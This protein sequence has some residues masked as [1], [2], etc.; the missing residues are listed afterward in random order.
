MVQKSKPRIA[1]YI[2]LNESW[3][4]GINYYR[5]LFL[6]L[7]YVENK[8]YEYFIFMPLSGKKYQ[9]ENFSDANVIYNDNF[10][11]KFA[12][13]LEMYILKYEIDLLSHMSIISNK[14]NC[15]VINWIPDFQHKYL[16]NYF[17]KQDIA[18]RDEK[19][20]QY[21]KYADKVLLSSYDA[22]KDFHKFFSRYKNKSAVL[23]FVA[24]INFD[25]LKQSIA[26]EDINKS[27]NKKFFFLPNQFWQHKNHLTVFKAILELKKKNIEIKLLCSG[28]MDDYRNKEHADMLKKFLYNNN[29]DNNIKLLG[30][31][32]SKKLYKLM[33]ESVC[34]INP[35]LFE[36]WST[37]VEECKTLC[38][39][40]I[41][42]DL[43]VHQ[44][45]N[46]NGYYFPQTDY[47]ALADILEEKWLSTKRKNIN[48]ADLEINLRQKLIIMGTTFENILNEIFIK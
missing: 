3:M 20:E 41:L 5:N 37:T 32:S 48:I 45:Q 19:F 34:V 4:G 21:A 43:N 47:L 17:S 25:E 7:K 9:L 27:K 15:K 28:H 46:P 13:T 22:E 33:W 29:L 39:D 23:R 30:S 2:N 6:S 16:P 42:S 12:D 1:F 36:G 40:M 11:I 31:I 35:S 38:K 8:Q 14:F 44:E 10:L 26:D 18:S 24:S